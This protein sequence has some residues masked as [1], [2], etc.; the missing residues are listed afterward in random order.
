MEWVEVLENPLLKNLPFKIELNKFGNLLMSPASNNHGRI[1]SRLAALLLN[2]RPN[3][4]VITECSIMTSDGVKVADVAWLSDSFIQK[5]DFITPYPKA[6]ELCIEIMSPSNSK[7][8]IEN[9]VELY[10]AKGASEVWVV[11]ELDDMQIYTH[12]GQISKSSLIS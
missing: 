3:G 10:L 1:Q 7:A 12:T 8:E 2:Q 6:P 11:F 9:K 5:Y 4:E